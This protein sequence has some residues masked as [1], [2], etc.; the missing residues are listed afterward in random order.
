LQNIANNLADAFTNY[1]YVIK[2]WNTTVNALKIVEVPMKT[3]QAPFVVKRRRITITK[4]DNA[5]NKRP[6]KEK[7]MHL[8]KT[9]NVGQ[10][11]VDRHLV[12]NNI[13]QSSTQA[14]YK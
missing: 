8:Q 14:V 5:P 10:P 12:G 6:R 9:V 1:K 3:T 11:V 2:S 7:T 13:P 4:M